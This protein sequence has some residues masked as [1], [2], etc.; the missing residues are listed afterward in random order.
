MKKKGFIIGILISAFFIYLAISRVA[1]SELKSAL[2]SCNYY[3]LIPMFALSVILQLFKSLRWKLILNPIKR[4]RL[5]MVY[6][7]HCIGFMG[8]NILPFRLGDL[9]RPYLMAKQEKLPISTS[10]ATTVVER[11]LDAGTL[12]IFIVFAIIYAPLPQNVIESGKDALVGIVVLI[13]VFIIILWKG[14]TFL[15]K[16]TSNKLLAPFQEKILNLFDSFKKGFDIMPDKRAVVLA[17]VI[18]LF[19]WVIPVFN[20]YLLFFAFDLKL[21]LTAALTAFIIISIGI[22]I[23]SA[24]GFIGNFQ[25]FCIIALS[26]YGI[27]K[28]EAL[29]FSI[30][31]HSVQFFATLGQ[32]IFSLIMGKIKFSEVIQI[33]K[34]STTGYN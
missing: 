25:Y 9:L 15:A 13:G 5:A 3:Y 19:F 29:A 23:P 21:P 1:Y 4:I 32:G 26:L 12:F 33:G 20:T 27:E 2:Q 24:P 8:I 31:L 16:M 6:Y 28:S 34:A 7:V 22:M 18:S 10:L 11:I 17:S 14:R 30:I